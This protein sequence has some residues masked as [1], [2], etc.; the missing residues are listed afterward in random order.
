MLGLGWGFSGGDACFL[1]SGG[2]AVHPDGILMILQ[3]LHYCSS[4]VPLPRMVAMFVLDEDPVSPF[5][6]G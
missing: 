4:V 5:Q 3:D 2:V 1:S 6:W